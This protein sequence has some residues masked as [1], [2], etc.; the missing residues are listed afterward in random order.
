MARY[1]A[2]MP[3]GIRMDTFEVG[4]AKAGA[5][6]VATG[7]LCVATGMDA[8]DVHIPVAII[9]G[10]EPG[11]TLLVEGG[12]HGVE[13]ATIAICRRLLE[14][15]DPNTLSG[16][17]VLAPQLNPWAFQ[18]SSRQTPQDFQDMNRVFPGSQGTTLSFQ[19]AQ[20]VAEQLLD[21]ADYVIDCHSCNPPSLHFT[22]LG[23]EGDTQVQKQ[24]LA[25]AQAFGY[26]I[27]QAG[28]N[29]HGTLSGYCLESG[30]PTITPEFVFSRRLDSLSIET[31]TVGI[32]N[33]LRSLDMVD[34]EI[35]SFQVPG[36]FDDV[37]SYQSIHA[38]KGGVCYFTKNCGDT[39]R[40]GEVIAELRTIWGHE[41]EL[42]RS[43]VD[44]IV[45]AYPL[46]ANQAVM[47]GDKVAYI[48]S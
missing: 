24:S 43:P 11:P 27:V 1:I 6:E 40:Q 38:E 8:R 30:K 2:M 5:G 47:S 12:L 7:E 15:L 19:V 46:Q 25:M 34:E 13:I 22:I 29:Y 17:V 37:R 39:V 44:G 10:A 48:A 41:V 35:E 3:E 14:T 18:A 28:T 21:I 33:V 23:V 4:T 16:T 32:M 42:I 20:V 45:I 26:P 9:R 36:A 31:G